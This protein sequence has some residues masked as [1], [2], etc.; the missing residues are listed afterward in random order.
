MSS[1]KKLT[2]RCGVIHGTVQPKHFSEVLKISVI[3]LAIGNSV[4]C[5]GHYGVIVVVVI[6][7]VV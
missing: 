6:G 2:A 5:R 7:P 3:F 1:H 4:N